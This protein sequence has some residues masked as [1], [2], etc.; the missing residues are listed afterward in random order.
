MAASPKQPTLL[1]LL[2]Q[3]FECDFRGRLKVLLKVRGMI[4]MYN[5]IGEDTKACG[6]VML[7]MLAQ[8]PCE[9]DPPAQT[10]DEVVSERFSIECLHAL[11]SILWNLT[12][13][14]ACP[15]AGGITEAYLREDC[16]AFI[17]GVL[18]L[19]SYKHNHWNPEQHLR[20]F[21]EI[22]N[23]LSQCPEI[24]KTMV[25]Q[26]VIQ[27]MAQCPLALTVVPSIMTLANLVRVASDKKNRMFAFGQEACQRV[28][29]LL[30]YAMADVN[31]HS[32]HYVPAEILLALMGMSE[33]EDNIR[34]CL[35]APYVINTESEKFADVQQ[36]LQFSTNEL[37]LLP[38]LIRLRNPEGLPGL[39]KYPNMIERT[40]QL[41]QIVLLNLSRLQAPLSPVSIHVPSYT[42]SSFESSDDSTDSSVTFHVPPSTSLTITTSTSLTSTSTSLTITTSLVPFPYVDT[43]LSSPSSIVMVPLTPRSPSGATEMS[44]CSIPPPLDLELS[45]SGSSSLLSPLAA[46]LSPLPLSPALS[47]AATPSTAPLVL[48]TRDYTIMSR[49]QACSMAHVRALSGL[50]LPSVITTILL[51]YCTP[52]TDEQFTLDFDLDGDPVPLTPSQIE[53]VAVR[54]L[55]SIQIS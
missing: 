13:V 15:T 49:L 22:L 42:S 28:I 33:N 5:D 55:D 18:P 21:F 50:Y 48:E 6:R 35:A 16:Q 20:P 41:A 26:G 7:E 29:E 39:V 54:E 52:W 24:A 44:V 31:I 8:R 10:P 2:T 53:A 4:G 19:L 25:E 23:N 38:L 47:R 43:N 46:L 14:L 32:G 37:R 36:R 12:A 45:R 34:S 30:P 11:G 1:P 9:W 40:A 51:S 27:Q 3:A 17:E